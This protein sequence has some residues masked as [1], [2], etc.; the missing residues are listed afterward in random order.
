MIII[1]AAIRNKIK[2]NGGIL[3]STITCR[4]Y[5]VPKYRTRYRPTLIISNCHFSNN[6]GAYLVKLNFFHHGSSFS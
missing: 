2:V 1:T 5:F 3:L 6:L 4:M